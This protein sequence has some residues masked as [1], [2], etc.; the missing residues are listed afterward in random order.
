MSLLS[1]YKEVY[2]YVVVDMNPLL[3][4]RVKKLHSEYSIH[5][6]SNLKTQNVL[7]SNS[8]F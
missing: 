2:L 3:N 5:K 7:K 1:I 4:K 8:E 6:M